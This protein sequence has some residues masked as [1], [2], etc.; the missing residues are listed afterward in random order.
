MQSCLT[1]AFFHTNACI[2]SRQRLYPQAF[3]AA[4]KRNV[5]RCAVSHTLTAAQPSSV[6]ANNARQHVIKTFWEQHWQALYLV[7]IAALFALKYYRMLLP[8]IS[9]VSLKRASLHPGCQATCSLSC[10]LAASLVA[11]QPF[12]SLAKAV[13]L[14]LSHVIS[15]CLR[16]PW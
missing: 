6:R 14:N 7:R 1:H 2:T 12:F 4:A 10:G 15:S 8:G 9:L 3:G 5:L 16:Q 11:W 13:N